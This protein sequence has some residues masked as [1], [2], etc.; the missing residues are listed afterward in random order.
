[1]HLGEERAI[2]ER[3]TSSDPHNATA[4][5]IVVGSGAGGGILA[6]PLAES[7]RTVFLL[8]AGGAP[9]TAQLQQSIPPSGGMP[10]DY[11][12]PVFHGYASENSA[13]KWDFYVRH[14]GSDEQQRQDPKYIE[15]MDGQRVDGILYP[16]A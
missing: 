7:G 3:M 12:V 1:M 13:I 5:Y 11:D 10:N 16:R 9:K 14:Y 6:A 2:D 15:T 4:E 8:E